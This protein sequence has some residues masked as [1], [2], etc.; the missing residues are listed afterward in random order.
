V[1]E[2]VNDEGPIV[3]EVLNEKMRLEN[4][5]NFLTD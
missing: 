5:R 3:E 4:L 1:V 2:E